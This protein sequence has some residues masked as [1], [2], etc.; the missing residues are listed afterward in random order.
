MPKLI[1]TTVKVPMRPNPKTNQAVVIN[2]RP[3]RG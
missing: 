3:V 1:K 2:P